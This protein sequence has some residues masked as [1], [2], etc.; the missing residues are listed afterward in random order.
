QAVA[1]LFGVPT[2]P[3]EKA[4]ILEVGCASG[5]N[6]IAMAARYPEA[7]CVGID[8]AERQVEIARREVAAIGLQNLRSPH[9]PLE[10]FPAEWGQF[11]Y[12]IVHGI[13]SWIPPD[14]QKALYALCGRALTPHGVAYLSYNALPGWN[15][16]RTARD[17]ML[18]HAG[19]ETEPQARMDRAMEILK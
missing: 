4:R 12:I 17:L 10:K 1:R 15:A 6:I 18:Y 9:M 5:A 11:D 16:V 19:E 7:T 13:L 8:H 2:A 3:P 14:V